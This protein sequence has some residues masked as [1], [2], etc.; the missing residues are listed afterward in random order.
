[1]I[2]SI[3]IETYLY[4]LQCCL[5][6]Y[7]LLRI[8]SKSK[9]LTFLLILFCIYSNQGAVDHEGVIQVAQL[10]VISRWADNPEKIGFVPRPVLFRPKDVESHNGDKKKSNSTTS[11]SS[12]SSSSSS[13]DADKAF[14]VDS[15]V[16]LDNRVHADGDGEGDGMEE[17]GVPLCMPSN[18][19]S[20]SG[21][22]YGSTKGSAKAE[23][24]KFFLNSG[25]CQRGGN[26]YNIYIYKRAQT[27][28]CVCTYA[29]ENNPSRQY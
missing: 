11:S 6:C 7:I 21:P 8:Y 16:S 19:G 23:I 20:G 5:L 24:C 18:P 27:H 4:V 13:I 12:S 26:A 10:T 17:R 9:R 22:G 25:S 15:G 3:C 2:L 1:M 29:A 14:E 28:V